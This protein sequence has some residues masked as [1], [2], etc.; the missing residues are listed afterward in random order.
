MFNLEGLVSILGENVEFLMSVIKSVWTVATSNLTLAANAFTSL[1]SLVVG[2]S[3]VLVNFI[4]NVVGS[5]T[6]V[7][8]EYPI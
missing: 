7:G 2:S 5:V 6:L 1:M 8:V 3:T 4:I